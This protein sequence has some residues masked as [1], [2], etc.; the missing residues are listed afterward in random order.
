MSRDEPW[1]TTTDA[2]A[3]GVQGGVHSGVHSGVQGGV[4]GRRAPSHALATIGANPGN[5]AWLRESLRD[6]ATTFE[7]DEWAMGDV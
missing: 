4:A 3:G 1:L 5:A 2:A 6:P 7:T